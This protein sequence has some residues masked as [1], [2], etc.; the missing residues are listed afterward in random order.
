M[1]Y[2]FVF[3]FVLV[4]LAN[5]AGGAALVSAAHPVSVERRGMASEGLLPFKL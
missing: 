5:A 1:G 3:V 2:P 4:P